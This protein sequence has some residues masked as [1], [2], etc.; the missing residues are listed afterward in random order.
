MFMIQFIFVVLLFTL[1]ACRQPVRGQSAK[2]QLVDIRISSGGEAL[3]GRPLVYLHPGGDKVCRRGLPDKR[4]YGLTHKN[5]GVSEEEEEA[6]EETSTTTGTTGTP[7]TTDT[8]TTNTAA[9]EEEE[10]NEISVGVGANWFETGLFIVNKSQT[11]WLIIETLSFT[12]YG[13]W[14][15]AALQGQ[16]EISSGYCGTDPLYTIPPAP[17]GSSTTSTQV[18]RDLLYQPNQ[19]GVLN[20]LK[21]YIDG[22]PIPTSPPE[23]REAESGREPTRSTR[24]QGEG[25]ANQ[26]NP[27]PEIFVLDRLPHYRVQVLARGYWINEKCETIHNFEKKFRFSLSSSFQN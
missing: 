14:G 27:E 1:G 17:K 23:R 25:G 10:D 7:T 15:N 20:N 19:S 16:K 5:C 9:E 22:V 24:D 21:L 6:E 11:E 2:N 18:R 3:D 13:T 8:E 26:V 4:V 12:I